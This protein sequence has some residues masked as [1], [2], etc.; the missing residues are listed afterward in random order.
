MKAEWAVEFHDDFD[1][2]FDAASGA[3]RFAFAFD[4]RRHGIIIC[5]GDKAGVDKKRFY[6]QFIA[7]ADGRFES[8][9]AKIREEER[10]GKKN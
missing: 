6:Q 1:P 2:E 3:W 9:C 4:P 5:G 10:H 7:K 8:H